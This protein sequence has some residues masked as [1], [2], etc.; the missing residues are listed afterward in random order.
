MTNRVEADDDGY[1]D[2][3]L[4]VW[5]FAGYGVGLVGLV[6][7][8]GFLG[9]QVVQWL[10][11][12]VWIPMPLASFGIREVAEY[13]GHEPLKNWAVSPQSWV[14]LHRILDWLNVAVAPMAAGMIFS[15]VFG[16][17]AT[18]RLFLLDFMS[19]KFAQDR[20]D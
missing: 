10:Q 4:A 12:E 7:S 14:G 2:L 11:Y 1:D 18:R 16:I 15:R 20:N 9:W 5:V 6:I 3:L 19:G 17:F 13:F 8:I